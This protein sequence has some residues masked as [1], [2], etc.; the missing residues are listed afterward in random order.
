M[1]NTSNNRRRSSQ[2]DPPPEKMLTP[3]NLKALC[4]ENSH[5]ELGDTGELLRTSL[6]HQIDDH[7]DREFTDDS[8]NVGC[9]LSWR[10]ISKPHGKP[11]VSV[12]LNNHFMFTTS[13]WHSTKP[14]IDELRRVENGRFAYENA[15]AVRG[16]AAYPLLYGQTP[17]MY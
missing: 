17:D 9:V 4:P 14:L 16:R 7:M 8:I 12:N 13:D 10:L 15:L 3:L 6:H 2:Y 11:N 5:Y 1:R